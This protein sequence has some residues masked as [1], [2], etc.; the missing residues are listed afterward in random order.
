[1][2]EVRRLGAL[3]DAEINHA[4]EVLAFEITKIVHGEE[5]AKKAQDAARALFANGGKSDDIPTTTYTKEQ[6]A[7]G[8]DLITLLVDTKLAP[9]RSEARRLIQQGG[10]TVNDAKITEFD[11]K[12]TGDDFDSDGVL[13]IK[14][15]KKGCT[16]H[17]PSGAEKARRR[18]KRKPG[19]PLQSGSCVALRWRGAVYPGIS[20]SSWYELVEWVFISWY[21]SGVSLPGLFSISFGMASFP[22]SC[23]RAAVTR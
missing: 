12:F 15:G 21:S 6:L 5:E 9:T 19:D 13:L 18:R 17:W 3:K 10:V 2:E 11:R 4:K 7:E 22:R 14:K 20:E 1:M 23:K 8:I 16:S